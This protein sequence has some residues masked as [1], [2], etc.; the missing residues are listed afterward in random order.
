[1]QPR[2]KGTLKKSKAPAKRISREGE[3]R[4]RVAREGERRDHGGK[5]V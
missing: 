3:R 1:V 5:S 4:E 2:T